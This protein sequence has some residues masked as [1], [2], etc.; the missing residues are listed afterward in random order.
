[1]NLRRFWKRKRGDAK[2]VAES[3]GFERA[4]VH[5]ALQPENA[6]RFARL[7]EVI[8]P[9]YT[10]WEWGRDSILRRH[11]NKWQEAGFNLLP[12]HY[13]VPVPDIASLDAA[14][15]RESLLLGVE[16][17]ES[18]QLGLL[19]DACEPFRQEYAALPEGPTPEPHQFHFNNGTF[20]HGDAE[21]LYSLVRHRKPRRMIEVGSGYSTLLAAAA[22]ERNRLEDGI[23]CELE[24]VEPFPFAVLEGGIP[25]LTRLLKKPLEELDPRHFEKLDAGDILFLDSTHVL[26]TGSDVQILYLEVL[27]RL[28]PGVLVHVHDIF[29]PFEYPRD[30]L[31]KEHVF[32]N[33]QY[34]LQAFLSF[35][36]SFRVVFSGQLMHQRHPQALAEVFPGYDAEANNPG[37]FWFER[38]E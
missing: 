5:Y 10:R 3:D 19:R 36:R 1:M 22:C 14:M 26:K 30:W 25:G 9:H 23:E 17:H 20:E 11:F 31:M 34:I 18:T 15:K 27:P 13:Y 37:S 12:N 2:G 6:D 24:A 38:I 33:E 21:L 4:I 7:L 8:L 28:R 35:N 29:L 16:V 32:W